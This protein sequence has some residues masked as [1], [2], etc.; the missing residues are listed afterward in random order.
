MAKKKLGSKHACEGCGI[1][2]YDFGRSPATC[3]KCGWTPGSTPDAELAADDEAEMDALDDG[4]LKLRTMYEEGE[5]SEDEDLI[6]PDVGAL[7]V[8]DEDDIGVE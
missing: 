7:D 2:F 8:E 3:P 6:D 1:K 5:G 4:V